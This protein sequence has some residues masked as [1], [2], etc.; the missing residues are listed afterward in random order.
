MVHLSAVRFREW[1][2]G[3]FLA[4]INELLKYTPNSPYHYI[5][6]SP[7]TTPLNFKLKIHVPTRAALHAHAVCFP[8]L[9][10]SNAR[11]SSLLLVQ[12]AART[13]CVAA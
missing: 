11:A 10:A 5:D 6:R 4:L 7:E 13:S 1:G 12:V 3:W 8:S 2:K 9:I